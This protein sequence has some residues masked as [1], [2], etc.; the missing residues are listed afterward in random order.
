MKIPPTVVVFG[1]SG[2]GKSTACQRYL[3]AHPEWMH[4]SASDLLKAAHSQSG[5]QLRTAAS[6]TIKQN[7]LALGEELDRRR[8]LQPNRPILVDAHSVID[9]DKTLTII[10]AET[11]ASLKPLGLIFLAAPVEV[12]VER[13]ARGDRVRPARTVIELENH[14]AEALSATREYASALALPIFVL[15]AG[16][17]AAFA[18]ALLEIAP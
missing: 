11:I 5:E 15:E 3:D 14:Q 1:I 16:D 2:V 17:D 13:R 7:Q 18:A 9:N 4:F 10:P 8:G 12:I 6:D